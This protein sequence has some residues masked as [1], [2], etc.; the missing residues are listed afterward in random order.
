MIT[1]SLFFA[2]V[3]VIATSLD[4]AGH[5]DRLSLVMVV[6]AKVYFMMIFAYDMGI[7]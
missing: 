6:L 1:P 7:W 2:G 3:L 5:K 4:R